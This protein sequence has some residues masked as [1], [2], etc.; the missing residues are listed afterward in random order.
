MMQVWMMCVVGGL[1]RLRQHWGEYLVDVRIRGAPQVRLC[2]VAACVS[3]TSAEPPTFSDIFPWTSPLSR[4]I[5]VFH[6]LAYSLAIVYIQYAQRNG[7]RD[8]EA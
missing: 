6:D 1:V 3:A 4:R 5:V 8:F 7:D 2:T